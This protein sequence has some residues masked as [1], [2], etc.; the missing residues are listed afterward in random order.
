[1]EVILLPAPQ[2]LIFRV[3]KM[4]TLIGYADYWVLKLNEN[5]DI[6]WQNTIGGFRI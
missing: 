3:T 5:G 6:I 4:K 2:I 1:M